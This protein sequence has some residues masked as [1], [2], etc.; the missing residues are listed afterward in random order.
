[1]QLQEASS[2]RGIHTNDGVQAWA[3]RLVLSLLFQFTVPCHLPFTFQARPGFCCHRSPL[4][5]PRVQRR[6]TQ[7]CGPVCQPALAPP[8]GSPPGLPGSLPLPSPASCAFALICGISQ[9]KTRVS[10]PLP[11]PRRFARPSGPL[12]RPALAEKAPAN[13]PRQARV[14]RLAAETRP[15]RLRPR[16]PAPSPS[17]F[18]AE[19]RPGRV[20]E[21]TLLLY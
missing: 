7:S 16:F 2:H 12:C 17:G 21:L 20:W 19:Q 1:M 18:M 13:P 15:G 14:V 4:S 10:G 8:L 3:C 11:Q 6:L 5:L 9:Q